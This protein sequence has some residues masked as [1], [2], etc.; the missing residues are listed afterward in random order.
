MQLLIPPSH[1]ESQVRI[2]IAATEDLVTAILR[3]L[4]KVGHKCS[5]EVQLHLCRHPA[6][7]LQHPHLQL[8]RQLTLLGPEIRNHKINITR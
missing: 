4:T 2:L 3:R 6:E 1:E 8:T 7:P 5:E